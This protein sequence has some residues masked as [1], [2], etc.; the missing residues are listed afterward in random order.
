MPLGGAAYTLTE[1]ALVLFAGIG[2]AVQADAWEALPLAPA[3]A[4]G[5]VY[6]GKM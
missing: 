5:S 1:G 6:Q 2:A 4:D 3:S